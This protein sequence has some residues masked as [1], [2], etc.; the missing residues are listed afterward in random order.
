MKKK[1][2][3]LTVLLL[4]TT[5]IFAGN[6]KTIYRWTGA[7]NN[8]WN[9][10][11]NW[12]DESG[13]VHTSPPS[14]DYGSLGDDYAVVIIEN[15]PN[16][17]II[18][19][20]VNIS[21]LI[22]KAGATLEVTNGVK[23]N[24]THE[25]KYDPESDYPIWD[26]VENYGAIIIGTSSGM[27]VQKYF[28]NKLNGDLTCNGDY[29]VHSLIQNF[30]SIFNTPT[31]RINFYDGFTN[32]GIFTIQSNDSGTGSLITDG[33]ISGSGTFN[34]ERYL[35]TGGIWHLVSAPLS[36]QTSNRFLGHYLNFYDYT[37]GD[38]NQIISTSYPFNVGEG[39]VS[40]LTNTGSA[41]N[42]I[43]FTG[44][45][46]T[47]TVPFT[48][49]LA[50]GGAGNTYFGL[51]Q[52]FHLLGNPY[53]SNL[54]WNEIYS[55]SNNSNVSQYLYYYVEGSPNHLGTPAV[56]N[57]WNVYDGS[58]TES[59]QSNKYISIGQGFGVVISAATNFT[60]PALARTHEAG[61]G[62]H[63]K[64]SIIN[65][66]FILKAATKDYYDE[67]T[68]KV[69]E[70]ATSNFDFNYDA[71]KLKSFVNSPNI[72]FVSD[73]NVKMAVSN[74]PFTEII[75]IGFSIPKN[76]EVTLSLSNSQGFSGIILE[77]KQQ[78]TF[79]DL[80][81][82]GYTFNYSNDESEIGR[83]TIHINR[84]TLSETDK[85]TGVKIYSSNGILHIQSDNNLS[86]TY[87]SVRIYN[88]MGQEVYSRNYAIL[89]D[90]RINIDFDDGIYII[91]INSDGKN[92]TSKISISK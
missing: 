80:I 84:E 89:K 61:I 9:T 86:D 78:N 73:D 70:N 46:P 17:P 56:K 57:G 90:E 45:Q 41:S 21:S 43:T 18:S 34:I 58:Q 23:I 48:K 12:V 68:F 75:N 82:D 50:T 22:L 91:R 77:D 4:S 16:H 55:D 25:Y 63:K 49:S 72:S 40:K 19:S 26:K 47:S 20:N 8:D 10:A 13:S 71:Y 52:N 36:G 59:D 51:P 2:V 3:L 83:F 60:I 88:T 44:G 33:T 53:T 7:T 28:D 87:T 65:N 38:F 29:I 92:I 85:L 74:S 32:D 14:N 66:Y 27:E 15:E 5:L 6:S 31:G 42:P 76:S 67:A 62:F 69:N 11:S 39:Y 1:I 79:T 54:D 24:I 30:G 35:N 81:K 64:S 37:N